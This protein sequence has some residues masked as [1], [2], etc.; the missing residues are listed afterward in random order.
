MISIT[1]C[2]WLLHLKLEIFNKEK[3]D[4][5]LE[6]KKFPKLELKKNHKA[7]ITTEEI[8]GSQ[9]SMPK[10]EARMLH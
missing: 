1:S 9:T 2:S 4:A 5:M 3:Y 8:K 7:W 6:K 10:K